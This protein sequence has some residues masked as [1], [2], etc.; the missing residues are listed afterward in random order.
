[1]SKAASNITKFSSGFKDIID[2]IKSFKAW[3]LMAWSDLEGRYSRTVIGPFWVSIAHGF[4]VFGYAFWSSAILKQDIHEQLPFVA[5]GLT[6]WVWIAS[7]LNESGNSLVKAASFISAYD[8]PSSLHIFRFAANQFFSLLHN[9]V[10]VLIVFALYQRNLQLQA[11]LAIFGTII[12]YLFTVGIGLIFSIMG[13]RYRDVPPLIASV[14]SGLFILT[15]IFWKKENIPS[16]GWIADINPFYHLIE[17]IRKPLM[18]S[19]FDAINWIVSISVTFIV[20]V[21]GIV[22]YSKFSNKAKYW[23]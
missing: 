15:P 8:L 17:I 23:L 9:L 3:S 5:I 1:M 4:F 10:I 20:L 13:S 7:A 2:G 6:I 14:V 22:T 19:D 12:V 16:A 11:L 21:I 18:G